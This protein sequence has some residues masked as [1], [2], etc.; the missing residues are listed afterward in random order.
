MHFSIEVD[1]FYFLVSS[2]SKAN[3]LTI[4]KYLIA[5]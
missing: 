3:P 5:L 2:K 4:I 1:L